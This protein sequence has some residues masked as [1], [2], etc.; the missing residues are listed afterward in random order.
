MAKRRPG[1]TLLKFWKRRKTRRVRQAVMDGHGLQLEQLERRE[2]MHAGLSDS[3]NIFGPL[4]AVANVSTNDAQA[5]PWD[6]LAAK[7]GT[8][9]APLTDAIHDPAAS[10]Q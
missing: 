3:E 9:V 2:L 8:I 6:A 1:E 5:N 7:D 4:P 10:V